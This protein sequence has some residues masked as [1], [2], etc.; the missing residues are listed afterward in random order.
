VLT[1]FTFQNQDLAD[2]VDLVDSSGNILESVNTAAGNTS[3]IVPVNWSLT[4]GT[5]YYL[6]QTTFDN[7]VFAN[8]GIAAPS[9][10]EIALT[11]R[12]F[13]NRQFPKPESGQFRIGR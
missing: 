11:D 3:E 7:G 5:Q 10:S 1:S 8:W 12:G 2:T 9:D 6:L 4:A 13:R